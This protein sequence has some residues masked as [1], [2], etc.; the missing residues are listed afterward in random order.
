MKFLQTI[1]TLLP[2]LKTLLLFLKTTTLLPSSGLYLY[3][4]M[5]KKTNL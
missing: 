4:K 5:A 2:S 1:T 3:H